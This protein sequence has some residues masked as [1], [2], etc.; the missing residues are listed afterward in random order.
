MK[1]KEED[2]YDKIAKLMMESKELVTSKDVSNALNIIQGKI[3]T[4][5]VRRRI[6]LSFRV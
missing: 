1:K 5:Y 6:I 3:L 4:I 2:V